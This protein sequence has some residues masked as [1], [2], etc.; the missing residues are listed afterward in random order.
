MRLM[1]LIGAL[2]IDIDLSL[3]AAR[4][5]RAMDQ[6]IEWRCKPLV[7]RSDNSPEYISS[8]F[9]A[10]AERHGIRLEH[11]QPGKPQQNAYIERFNRTVRYDWLSHY[12]FESIEDGAELC[13]RLDVDLQSRTPQHGLGRHHPETEVSSLKPFYF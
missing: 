6:V 13:N 5:T 10:W 8:T 11:I 3:P 4:V 1:T 9:A 12:L 7:I 2:A